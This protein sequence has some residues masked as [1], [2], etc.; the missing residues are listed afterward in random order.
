MSDIASK[1]R[2]EWTQTELYKALCGIFPEMRTKQQNVLDVVELAG[3]LGVSRE[4]IYKWLRGGVILSKK[5]LD[6]LVE[7]ANR[8]KY[9][10]ALERAGTPVPNKE[11]LAR[12]LV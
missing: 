1:P 7:V 12:F 5:G 6:K 11:G 8:P 9:L 2:L 10:A 4:C 3:E